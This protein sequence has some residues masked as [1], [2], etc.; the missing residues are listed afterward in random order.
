MS[1]E[2]DKPADQLLEAIK[3]WYKRTEGVAL[4]GRQQVEK[5]TKILWG[6]VKK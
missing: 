1:K 3:Q 6:R 2:T 4:T 5:A